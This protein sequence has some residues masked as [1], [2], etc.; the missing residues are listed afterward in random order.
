MPFSGVRGFTTDAENPFWDGEW[1]DIVIP[2][3]AMDIAPMND[4]T[5]FGNLDQNNVAGFGFWSQD[6]PRTVYLDNIRFEGPAGALFTERFAV[7]INE[8]GL[9]PWVPEQCDNSQRLSLED[10]P[11]LILFGPPVLPIS[12]PSIV[13]TD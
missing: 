2:L 1:H 3:D 9:S 7:R 6:N 12:P 13:I 5:D 11:N 4:P 10:R 8:V